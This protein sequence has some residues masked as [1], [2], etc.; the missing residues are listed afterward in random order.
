[1]KKVKKKLKKLA[2]AGILCI[3]NDATDEDTLK[4]ANFNNALGAAVLDND[5]DNLF[6]TLSIRTYNPNI[7]I[8]SRCAREEEQKQINSCWSK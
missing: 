7:H 5:R 1:M 2:N 4:L 6:V 8:I 3:N